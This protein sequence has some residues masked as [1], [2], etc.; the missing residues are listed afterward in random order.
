MQLLHV[1]TE[2]FRMYFILTEHYPPYIHAIYGNDTAEITIQ[3]GTLLEGHLPSKV[4]MSQKNG[5]QSIA[6]NS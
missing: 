5:F 2:S 4:L 3:D 6:G 1:Y